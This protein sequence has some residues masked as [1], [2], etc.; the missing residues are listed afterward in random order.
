MREI[1]TNSVEETISL[2]ERIGKLLKTQ[3]VVALYGDL[4]AGKTV[5]IKGIMKGMGFKE[6][7]RSPCF[8][9]INSYT[10]NIKVYHI[11]LFR[12]EKKEEIKELDIDDFLR[13][14]AILLIEWAERI[15]HLLP[16][17]KI[18]IRIEIVEENKRRFKIK[19][20]I[21]KII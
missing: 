2:G 19:G 4:G 13:E 14:K 17:D 16:E 18:E 20:R 21:E 11:D 5:L 12:I 8:T 10:N 1:Q 3:D 6:K 9:L 15:D 7:I